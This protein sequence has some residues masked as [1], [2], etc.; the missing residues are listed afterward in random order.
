[1]YS[2]FKKIIR[3]SKWS[4]IIYSSI[5]VVYGL[6]LTAMFPAIKKQAGEFEKI[7]DAFPDVM[8]EA[9]G[10]GAS[11]L[12]TIEGFLAVEYFSLMWII[13]IAILIFS[14]GA[15]IVANEIDRGTSEFAFT[16]PIKRE[17]IV[18]GKFVASFLVSLIVAAASLVSVVVFMYAINETPNIGGFLDFAAIAAA[19]IFFLLAFTTFFSSILSSKG[20]VYGICGGF[21]ALS[22]TLHVFQGISEKMSDIYFL[23]FFKYYGSPENILKGQGIDTNNTY[24]FLIAG[25]VFLLLALYAVRKRDL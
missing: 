20:A 7:F 18:L 15:S 22:Y 3:D 16:L 5:V 12:S 13:I 21:L 19:M 11:S 2:F 24:V 6:M 4:I 10:I 23:S 1:M 25:V 8:K 9:F 17:K 14:L